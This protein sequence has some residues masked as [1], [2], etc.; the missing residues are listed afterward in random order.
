MMLPRCAFLAAVLAV[1][2]A[3]V[4][5]GTPGEAVGVVKVSKGTVSVE[6]QGQSLPATVGTR[7]FQSDRLVTGEDGAVGIAFHDDSLLSAG[8]DSVL[9]IDRFVFD[10][11]TYEGSFDAS[12]KRG[13]LSVVS[14]KI[15]KQSPGA[16]R[17]QTPAAVLAVRGTEFAVKA[18]P[19]CGG[20]QS[21]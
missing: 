18:T 20:G 4:W 21:E 19:V 17:V 1:S 2:L 15:V 5:A 6:R 9:V 14:G 3:P 8:P 10:S 13:T 7:V 16:M 12:L 11:T